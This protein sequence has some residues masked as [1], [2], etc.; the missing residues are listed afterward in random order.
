MKLKQGIDLSL[1]LKVAQQ[2]TGGVFFETDEGDRLDLKS[3]LSQFVFTA[4]LAARLSS[5][6]G[7]ICCET[8]DLPLL[9]KF[10]TA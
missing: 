5:T 8:Q 2:C 6:T 1:F 9:E 4:A 7:R 3:T 10:L